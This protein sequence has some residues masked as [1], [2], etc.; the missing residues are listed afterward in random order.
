[1][2]NK[3]R[4]TI[5]NGIIKTKQLGLEYENTSQWTFK[6]SNVPLSLDLR[7]HKVNVEIMD[8]YNICLVEYADFVE[9]DFL[10]DEMNDVLCNI[11]WVSFKEWFSHLHE[12][13]IKI[14]DN[15]G[16]NIWLIADKLCSLE[17]RIWNR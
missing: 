12:P 11:T 16:R 3:V 13:S 9:E 1:M 7:T 10:E 2:F 15:F 17:R 14:Q 5:T 4:H 8:P 6:S